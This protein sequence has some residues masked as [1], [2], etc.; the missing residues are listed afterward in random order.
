MNP[1]VLSRLQKKGT[2]CLPLILVNVDVVSEGGHPGRITILKIL[3]ERDSCFC[4]DIA[5]VLPLAQSTISQHLK[6]L[7]EVELISRTVDS[8]R[9][10]YCLNP[11]AISELNNILLIL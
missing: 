2:E 8:V 3:M 11:D 5:D 9:T 10:C 6:A 1:Q 7:K 4:G